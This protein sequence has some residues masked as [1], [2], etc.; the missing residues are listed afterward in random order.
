MQ[1][2]FDSQTDFSENE[3]AWLTR[4]SPIWAYY[5]Y[6]SPP[7]AHCREEG[8][9]LFAFAVLSC[10]LD[11]TLIALPIPIIWRLKMRLRQRLEAIALLAVGFV[12]TTA[13]CCRAY[14][15]WNLWKGT[16][17]YSWMAYPVFVTTDLEINLGIV[18]VS[19]SSRRP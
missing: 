15:I 13:T 16:K 12:A 9:E 14:Y 17:D 6:P 1:V 3:L 19:I 11:A 7:G 18:C 4:R 5:T 8:H 10:V 2:R